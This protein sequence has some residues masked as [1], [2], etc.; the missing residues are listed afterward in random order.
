MK[1][2]IILTGPTASGK[3]KAALVLADKLGAEIVSVD[4]MKVYRGMD[5]GTDKPPADVLRR[6][7]HHLI[8]TVDPDRAYS[9]GRF[10]ED[11]RAAIADITGRGRTPLFAGGTALY[12]KILTEGIFKG[13]AADWEFREKL[14]ARAVEAGTLAL[15]E[16]LR[17]IDPDSAARIHPNDLRRIERAL[18]V[19]ATTGR[20]MT[21]LIAETQ[22]H[23]LLPEFRLFAMAPPRRLQY[24]RINA[25][26]DRMFK[27][28]LVT[29]TEALVERYG[30]LSRQAAQALGYREIL[31][32]LT[33]EPNL[34]ETIEL[35][36]Q[37][38]RNFAKRQETWLRNFE[39]SKDLRRIAVDA[40]TS[41]ETAAEKILNSI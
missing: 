39:V 10:V 12:I 8:N 11:V 5:I 41:P 21:E 23:A 19:H 13:P 40:D 4:S 2:P 29:E 24:E 1:S 33:G 37:R 7:P 22:E 16:E 31:A 3:K 26:V 27:A 6:V 28:G 32:Y 9:T 35:V 14:R 15:H 18:E 36:K 38:T 25:R 30:S 17:R 20:A 34:E